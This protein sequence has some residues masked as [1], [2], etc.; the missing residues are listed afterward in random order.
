M[1]I[2]SPHL[3]Q[4]I[5]RVGGSLAQHH[6]ATGQRCPD[7][8]SSEANLCSNT[9]RC[10]SIQPTAAPAFASRYGAESQRISTST[11]VGRRRSLVS[12]TGRVSQ[13]EFAAVAGTWAPLKYVLKIGPFRLA[14]HPV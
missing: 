2:T 5:G 3:G 9:A 7:L 12:I 10:R 1:A 13:A 8:C 6:I 14:F 11:S 4:V